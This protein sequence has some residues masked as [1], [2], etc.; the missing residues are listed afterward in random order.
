MKQ[1]VPSVPLVT[2]DPYF[3][4]WSPSN[5][6]YESDTQNWT[7]ARQPMSGWAKID[8]K[9][10]RFLGQEGPKDTLQQCS[11]D[12]QAM[13]T[14]YGFEGGGIR[15]G[16]KFTSPLLLNDLDMVSR[17]C[18][19]LDFEVQS[20]DGR[21]HDVDL[22]FSMDESHCHAESQPQPML[23]ASHTYSGVRTVW[24]GKKKQSPL[25]HSGDG[26]TIDWGYLYLAMPEEQPGQ[27]YY[28]NNQRSS[29]GASLHLQAAAQPQT[30]TLVLGYDDTLSIMYFG[31]AH[32]AYWARNGKTMLDVLQEAV[33]QHAVR[34]VQCDVFDQQLARQCH[35]AGGESYAKIGRLAYRQTIAA[36]KLI[37]NDEGQVIFLSKEC[38]S[39][40]CIGTSDVS[41]PSVPLYLLYQPEL[42]LGM[43]RPI[44]AFAN[45][46][47]WE[48]D[49]A[50][51]DVGRYPYANGQVYGVT[52]QEDGGDWHMPNGAV[53]P[54]YYQYPQ[55]SE[56]YNLYMQMPVEECG[57]MLIMTAA[58]CLAKGDFSLAKAHDNLLE[59]WAAYLIQHSPDPGE[60]LCTDDF[61]GHLAH[62]VN[63]SAKGVM[64]VYSYAIILAQTGREDQARQYAEKAR[65][66]AEDWLRRAQTPQGTALTFAPLQ[67]WSLKYNL[68]WDLLFQSQLFPASF[69]QKEL[70]T[71]IQNTN[72]YGVPLDSRKDYTKSDWILW[73]AA[74]AQDEETA[75]KLIRPI[76]S[77]LQDTPS[78][79]P[80]SDWYD[81][82]T[83]AYCHFINR[84]VQGGLFMPLLRK[85]WE[86]KGLAQ[87]IALG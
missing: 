18:T 35:Q 12:I 20:L 84:T 61:A 4:I 19:Y 55:G 67:G 64:G 13:S 31:K 82:V 29:L 85:Q 87:S 26:I 42:V 54:P 39:N 30:A 36:H 24:M 46:P 9:S 15:L 52:T 28:Q 51:H 50:P 10:F 37:V 41:Y 40:G 83:G 69:Y 62:N 53:F 11:L 59:K 21:E 34:L 63:L 8:G 57:N 14:C 25:N 80:F 38:D 77:Y 78:R 70:E 7:G 71:Y 43:L 81:T 48:F 68:V 73:V 22:F 49:F 17:P 58:A 3:S 76:D 27:L 1:Q 47:V 75:S 72:A 60:Q 56:V 79:V 44:F 2:N 16:V 5:C 66:M 33:Q 86:E 65:A 74:M 6:L 32:K 45:M 23:T